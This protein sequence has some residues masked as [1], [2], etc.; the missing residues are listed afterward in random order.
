MTGKTGVGGRPLLHLPGSYFAVFVYW[1]PI[2]G[3]WR[4]GVCFRRRYVWTVSELGVP[5]VLKHVLRVALQLPELVD[6]GVEV[7]RRFPGLLCI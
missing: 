1:S 5:P 3:L 7:R 4:A 2:F 6:V